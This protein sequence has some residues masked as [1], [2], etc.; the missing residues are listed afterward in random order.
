MTICWRRAAGVL[1]LLAPGAISCRAVELKVSRDLLRRALAGSTAAT[2]FKVT[3]ERLKVHSI[4]IQGD[5]LVV[6]ADGDVSVK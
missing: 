5:A 4:L 6:D 2:G 3:L 1:L